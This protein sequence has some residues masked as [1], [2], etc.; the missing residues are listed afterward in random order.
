MSRP[1]LEYPN[2]LD[3]GFSTVPEAYYF[4]A[5][6]DQA[7]ELIYRMDS[8]HINPVVRMNCEVTVVS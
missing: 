1:L 7:Y 8:Y 2:S 3:A 5:A 4:K 6:K